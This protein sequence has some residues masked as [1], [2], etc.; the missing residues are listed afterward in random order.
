MIFFWA[1][2]TFFSDILDC[3]F[4]FGRQKVWSCFGL[5]FDFLR[6][7]K[8]DQRNCIKFCVKNDIKCART[9]E[10]LTVSFCESTMSRT[11]SL[12]VV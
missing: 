3:Q 6:F 12:I 4:V 11:H 2:L 1:K 8:M 7:E 5:L 10:I 9:F